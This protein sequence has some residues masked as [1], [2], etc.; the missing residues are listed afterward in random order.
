MVLKQFLLNEI[1]LDFRVNLNVNVNAYNI[2]SSV[3]DYMERLFAFRNPK[4]LQRT[5]INDEFS[6]CANYPMIT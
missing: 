3:Y 1:N 2:V 6:I 4:F 5:L